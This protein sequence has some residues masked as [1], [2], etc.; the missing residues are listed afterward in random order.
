MSREAHPQ[1]KIAAFPTP[2]AGLALA[3]KPDALP[4]VHPLRDL[5][6]VTFHLVGIAA[7]QGNL[8]LRSV[9]RF[10]KGDHDVRFHVAPTFRAALALPERAPSEPRLSA[11]AEELLEEI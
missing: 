10:L 7:A 6:L 4:L 9:E 1:K 3:C 2:G 5:D 11:A 8:P